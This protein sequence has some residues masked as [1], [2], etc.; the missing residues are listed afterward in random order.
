MFKTSPTGMSG[1]ALTSDGDIGPNAAEFQEV[2]CTPC[3]L[4]NTYKIVLNLTSICQ[5]QFAVGRSDS[6]A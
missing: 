4:T 2:A 3:G 6:G 5:R 1:A